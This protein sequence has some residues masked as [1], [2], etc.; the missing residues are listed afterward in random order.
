MREKQ[1]FFDRLPDGTLVFGSNDNGKI[2]VG[3]ALPN[4]P[5]GSVAEFLPS[6]PQYKSMLLF[7]NGMIELHKLRLDAGSR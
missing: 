1:E 6:H 3:T 4:G 2:M 5:N 7:V